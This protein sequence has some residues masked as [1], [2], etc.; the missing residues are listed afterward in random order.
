MN[1]GQK[2]DRYL[3]FIELCAFFT[4]GIGL[5][6]MIG[7]VLDSRFLFSMNPN[8]KPM[9]PNG[10]LSSMIIG[11]SLYVLNNSFEWKRNLFSLA[12]LLFF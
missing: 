9:P 5:V 10:A 6:A 12:V 3:I 8:Y 1:L 4:F 2:I 7:W 11:F